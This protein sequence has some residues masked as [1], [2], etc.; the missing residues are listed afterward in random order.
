MPAKFHLE[1]YVSKQDFP[2]FGPRAGAGAFLVKAISQRNLHPEKMTCPGPNLG[3]VWLIFAQFLVF[4]ARGRA[5]AGPGPGPGS[6]ILCGNFV[7]Q[8][9]VAI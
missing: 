4:L 1:A 6:Y 5:R 2:D 3:Q 7:W 9:S 8:F